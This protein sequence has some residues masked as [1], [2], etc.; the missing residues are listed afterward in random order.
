MLDKIATSWKRCV[1]YLGMLWISL[2]RNRTFTDLLP[3][4]LHY[5]KENLEAVV[6]R[7]H[8]QA[9]ES[10]KQGVPEGIRVQLQD[11]LVACHQTMGEQFR[12]AEKW[13]MQEQK[14]INR[15]FAEAIAERL[16]ETYQACASETGET[17]SQ[18]VEK[19]S[20]MLATTGRGSLQRIRA[21]MQ[22][23]ADD[24]AND[25]LQGSTENAKHELGK[26]LDG[27]QA[28]VDRIIHNRLQE[29]TVLSSYIEARNK[30][31]KCLMKH[32][33]SSEI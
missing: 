12:Q 9:I 13:T 32:G 6:S 3:H 29:H 31:S 21:L 4:C 14:R 11:T 2:T 10:V 33:F 18:L 28:E 15:T 8:T 5:L 16:K 25:V 7:F 26:L 23:T 1:C 17:L 19:Y 22:Q 27:Q 30:F 24:H 20:N